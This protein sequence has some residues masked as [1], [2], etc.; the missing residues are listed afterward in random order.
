MIL[1]S[2]PL[3]YI[4][5]EDIEEPLTPSHLITGQRLLSLPDAA[6][7]HRGNSDMDFGEMSQGDLNTR[8]KHLNVTPNHFWKR[9]RGEYLLQLREYNSHDKR[10][11]GKEQPFNGEVVL[12]RS[13]NKL[14]GF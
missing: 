1:N 6:F 5:T 14:K 10:F 8:M 11:K 7:Y 12:L 3:S 9:W 13:D 2:R 4:S